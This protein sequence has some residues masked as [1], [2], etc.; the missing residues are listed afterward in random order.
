MEQ[1]SNY[2]AV[3]DAH[4]MLRME[5]CALDMEQQSKSE[6]CAAVKDAQALLRKEECAIGMEQKRSNHAVV[7]DVKI[8]LSVAECA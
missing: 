1:R 8:K 5:E 2:A 6:G 3:K 4:S 7:K